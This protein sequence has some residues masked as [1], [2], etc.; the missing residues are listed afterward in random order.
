MLICGGGSKS[1]L[2]RQIFADVYDMEI[3]K[4][5]VDQS[6]ATLG[7]AAL[8]ANGV[9]IWKGY[10]MIPSFHKPEGIERPIRENVEKYKALFSV[11]QKL[12]AFTAEIGDEMYG[13]QKQGIW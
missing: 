3:I 9:G 13:L 11:F 8:A 4:T 6:A 12:A 2:W 10:D 5:N 1:G 7:A